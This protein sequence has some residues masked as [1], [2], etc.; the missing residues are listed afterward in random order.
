MGVKYLEA[1]KIAPC[2]VSLVNVRIHKRF[3]SNFSQ[4]ALIRLCTLRFKVY[5]AQWNV[6]KLLHDMH[7]LRLSRIIRKMEVDEP[8]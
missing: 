5:S 3:S 6:L 7:M 1:V 2:V 8:W 4:P